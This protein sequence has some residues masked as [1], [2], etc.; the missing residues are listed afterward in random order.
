MGQE[1][2]TSSRKEVKKVVVVEKII[3]GHMTNAEG[4]AVYAYQGADAT[5]EMT[6]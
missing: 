3:S 2:L 1:T 6:H 4:A 5:G